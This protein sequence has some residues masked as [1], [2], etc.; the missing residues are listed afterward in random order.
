MGLSR[1]KR[2]KKI[3]GS[4]RLS[5]E[6]LKQAIQEAKD[7]AREVDAAQASPSVVTPSFPSPATTPATPAARARKPAAAPAKKDIEESPRD[8]VLVSAT[9]TADPILAPLSFLAGCLEMPIRGELAPYNQVFQ[10]L[11]NPS[12]GF[13]SNRDGMNLILLRFEDWLRNFV[14][15]DGHAAA[16]RTTRLT[17]TFKEY[18]NKTLADFI[19]ALQSYAGQTACH[20]H[21][22]LCP[23]TPAYDTRSWK[24]Q[25]AAMSRELLESVASL[26]GVDGIAAAEFH[27]RYQ[28]TAFHDEIRDQV[29]HIPFTNEYFNVLGALAMRRYFALSGIPSK[30]IV[31]DCD[32]TLWGG[33]CGEVGAEGIHL[34]EPFASL[35]KFL[36]RQAERGMVLCLC[37]KNA[38]EDV[39][40][41]FDRRKEMPLKREHVVDSR[42]NWTPKSQNLISLAASLNLGLDSFIFIDDNPVECA[43]V[44]ANCPE[45]LTFQWPDNARDAKRFLDH[46]WVFD[47]YSVTVEDRKRTKM[48]QANV[49]R[50]NLLATSSDFNKFL[51]NLEL[52]IGLS[53]V[54]AETLPRLAQLTNRTNQFNFTTM[55]RSENDVRKILDAQTHQ[56]WTAKVSDRFGD[57]GLVGVM[58]L[59]YGKDML[60][61]DSFLLSCRVLGR[62]VEYRMMAEVG[63][64]AQKRRLSRVEIPF[65]HTAKNEPARKFIEFI[66]Q[67]FLHVQNDQG[68]TFHFP[69]KKLAN[70]RFKPTK[71]AQAGAEVKGRSKSASEAASEEETLGAVRKREDFFL[72][73]RQD[74]SNMADL[75]RAMSRGEAMPDLPPSSI[76]REGPVAVT[77]SNAPAG[78]RPHTAALRARLTEELREIFGR[79]LSLSPSALDPGADLE[80]YVDDSFKNV[81]IMVGLT[82]AFEDIPTTILFEARSIAA[83]AELLLESDTEALSA[84][85]GIDRASRSSRP[86]QSATRSTPGLSTTAEAELTVAPTAG[87][88]EL[89]TTQARRQDI[90]IIGLSGKYPCANNLQELWR[91][92]V[93]GRYCV[94]EVPA[95]RW[96]M[97]A[98]F[99][100]NGKKPDKSYNKWGGFI[101]QVSRFDPSFFQITPKEAELMDPQQRL[102]LQV[103][104]ALLEDAGYVRTNLEKNTGVFVGVI[105]SDYSTLTSEAS[106]KGASAYRGSDYYQIPN[107]VSYFFDFK[108][109]SMAIDTACSASGTS[110]HMACESLRKGECKLAIAGG[111]NLFLHP[112]RYVQYAQLQFFSQDDKIRPFG[113]GATGTIFGEGIGA[114]LLKPLDDAVRDGDN[115]QGVIKAT[116]I[117]SGG[118]TNGFTVPNPLAQA[119]LIAGAL[120]RSNIDPRSISYIEAHGTGTPLGDPIEIRGLTLAFAR[121]SK[122]YRRKLASQF[123]AVGSIKSNIGHLE[124]GAAISGITKVL[125]QMR[126]KTLV[127]S[128]NAEKLNPKI[129]LEKTPFFIQRGLD[130]WQRPGFDED[131]R[132]ISF[133]RRAGISSFGAGGA[134]AHIIVE[135]FEREEAPLSS[136]AGTHLIV[137]SAKT[138]EA[139][140]R[141]AE[142]L[143]DF[144]ETPIPGAEGRSAPTNRISLEEIAYTQQTG[145]EAMGQRLAVITADM[146]ELIQKLHLFNAGGG[147]TNIEDVFKGNARSQKSQSDLLIS[148]EE[149]QEFLRL[150]IHNRRLAKLAQ[151]WVS[152]VS[153]DWTLIHSGSRPRRISLP[154]YPF[155]GL[156]FWIPE[157]ERQ[158]RSMEGEALPMLSGR[159]HP[160]LDSNEST[161]EEQFFKKRLNGKEF[162]LKDHVLNSEM[163][164]PAVAY[165]E[166]ARAAG[167]LASSKSRVWKLQ[168]IVWA[169]RI[170]L[171]DPPQDVFISLIP[172]S[173]AVEYEVFTRG[174]DEIRYMHAQGKLLYAD[175]SDSQVRNEVLDLRA[176][177]NRCSHKMTR[178]ACYEWYKAEG[179]DYGPGFK[180]IMELC[181]NEVE[182]LSR[183]EL[184]PEAQDRFEQFLLHPTIMDGALQS[185]IALTGDTVRSSSTPYL[186]FG[187]GE[188]EILQPLTDRCHAYVRLAANVKAASSHIKKFDVQIVDDN[189]AVLVRLKDYSL[190]AV[191]QHPKT[192]HLPNESTDCAVMYYRGAW[193]PSSREEPQTVINEPLPSRLLMFADDTAMRDAFLKVTPG[194]LARPR[195]LILVMPGSGFR[196]LGGST[197][198]IHPGHADD[199]HKLLKALAGK[200]GIP[201]HLLHFWSQGRFSS[202]ETLLNMQ[203]ER[204]FFSLFYLTQELM[205]QK[206]KEPLNLLYFFPTLAGEPKPQY[207]A[208]SGFAHT[209][210]QENPKFRLRTVAVVLPNQGRSQADPH[211][212]MKVAQTELR[213]GVVGDIELR[214]TQGR[215]FNKVLQEFD[216][217]QISQ[218][219]LAGAHSSEGG[220]TTIPLRQKGTYLITGGAGGLGLIFAEH[221]AKHFKANLALVGRSELSPQKEQKLAGLRSL[222]AD[223]HYFQADISRCERVRQLIGEVRSRFGTIHGIIH[224]AGVI[225]DSFVLKKTRAD[226]DQVLAAKVFGT[227]YLDQ[228]TRE[229]AL[230]FFVMFSSLT[231]IIGNLGQAD[232]AYGNRYMDDFAALR[233]TWRGKGKRSGK[234][235][236]INWPFWRDG[237]MRVDEH[238]R[239]MIT[240]TLGMKALSNDIG[241][242]TFRCGLARKE[243]QVLVV[244]GERSKVQRSLGLID[245]EP[246]R[247][248][249]SGTYTRFLSTDMEEAKTPEAVEP[250]SV[251]EPPTSI[252]SPPKRMATNVDED[253]LYQKAEHFLKQ[254]LSKESKLPIQKII[255][256]EPLEEYGIDSVMILTMNNELEKVF[257]DLS[258]TLLFEYQ[259]ISELAQYFVENHHEKLIESFGVSGKVIEEPLAESL[260]ERDT[261]GFVNPQRFISANM[262]PTP[263]EARQDEDIAII[264]LNGRFPRARDLEEFWHNLKTGKDCIEEIPPDRW[265]FRKFY[266][267]DK[268]KKGK[269][270]SKWGG[271]IADADQ[272]DPL[273]FNIS[274]REAELM[275]PQERVFLETACHTVEDAGYTR[276]SLEKFRVGVYVGVMWGQY[277][278]I[279]AEESLKGNVIATDSSYSTIANRV[280]YWFNLRGPSL[281]VDS[282]CSS[283]LTSIHL[284][285][286]SI[287]RGDIEMAIA[288]GVN[289]SLHPSKYIL[290][291]QGK[292][293]SSD[294]RCRSFGQGGDGYVPGEGSGAVMLKSLSKAISD[295]DHIYAII[296]GT[297]INHGGKTNGYSVPNPRAQ[298]DLVRGALERAKIDPLTLSY[299]EAHG[300]GTSLGDPIEITGLKRAFGDQAHKQLCPIGSVKSNIGHLEAAAGIAGLAKILLQLK[301]RQI[302]PSLHSKT[303]NPNINFKDS[304]FV[305]QQELA[306]WKQPV[307]NLNGEERT[308]PRRAGISSFGAGGSNAHV[309]VEE[310]QNQ[311]LATS[312]TA[313]GPQVIVLSAKNMDRL[314]AYTLDIVSFMEKSLE[315]SLL[316][317]PNEVDFVDTIKADLLGFVSKIL[318][319]ELN[320][321]DPN[322]DLKEYGFDPIS[323]TSLVQ[324]INDKYGL[325]INPDLF[326]LHPSLESISRI[327][328]RERQIIK[329]YF[330]NLKEK[331]HMARTI[332]SGAALPSLSDFA[333]TLQIG[334]EPLQERIALVVSNV[335]EMIDILKEFCQGREDMNEFYNGNIKSAKSKS[336][337]LIEGEEGKDFIKRIIGKRKLAKL[338][339]LWV[340]GVDIDWSLLH[341]PH[342]PKRISLPPQPFLRKRYWIPQTGQMVHSLPHANGV[343]Q[344]HPMVERNTSTFREERFSTRLDGDEFYLTDPGTLGIRAIPGLAFLELAFAAGGLAGEQKVRGIAKVAWATPVSLPADPGIPA[345]KELH[346]SLYPNGEAVEFEISTNG[347]G[348]NRILHS[349][350]LLRFETGIHREEREQLPLAEIQQRCSSSLDTQEAYRQLERGAFLYGPTLQVIQ[351]VYQGDS[352]A[353]ALLRLPEPLEESAHAFS[354]HPGLFAGV[355]QTI[356]LLLP[357]T[358][359][360]IDPYLPY[361]LDQLEVIGPLPKTCFAHVI[362]QSS[363]A[364][365]SGRRFKVLLAETSGRVLVKM[366]GLVLKP[367][368]QCRASLAESQTPAAE[369]A[370]YYRDIWERSDLS[371]ARSPWAAI[372]A[373]ANLLIFDSDEALFKTLQEQASGK[374]I[375]PARL[376]LVKPGKSYKQLGNGIFRIDPGQPEHYQKLLDT[377]KGEG[378]FPDHIIHIWSR[379]LYSGSTNKLTTLL[380][381]SIYSI[382]HL[383]R[384]LME[385]RPAQPVKLIYAFFGGKDDPQ[386][387]YAAMSAMI[388]TIRKESSRFLY[389]SVA[390]DTSS[391][392]KL[393]PPPLELAGMLLPEF[394][395]DRMDELEVR[396]GESQRWSKHL[397]SFDPDKFVNTWTAPKLS[398]DSVYLITGGA[399]GLGLIFARHIATQIKATLILTGR[400]DLSNEKENE[401]RALEALGSKVVYRKADISRREDVLGLLAEIR[402]KYGPL[403]GII[404][405][406]GIIRDASILKKTVEEIERVL[407]VKV[408]GTVYLDEVTRGDKLDFFV[409]FSSMTAI[410]GNAGQSDY[411]YANHFMD[412]FAEL[413][414]IL[415]AKQARC[416]KTIAINWPLWRDGGMRVDAQTEKLLEKTTGMRALSTEN[417][418]L[419]FSKGLSFATSRFLVVEGDN[420]KLSRI[421]EGQDSGKKARRAAQKT[422]APA[423]QPQSKS[424]AAEILT[425]LRTDLRDFISGLLKVEKK[426]I[427]LSADM[428]DFGF[429]SITLTEFSNHVN[430]RY[431]LEITPAIF[432]E[433]PSLESFS[434]FLLNEYRA[435]FSDHYQ[436][437]AQILPQPV[438]EIPAE[439]STDWS[440]FLTSE[441]RRR[442]RFEELHTTAPY[443][444]STSSGP[445]ETI[446]I[447][448]MAGVM[449]QSQDLESFWQHLE[450]GHD[451]ITEVPGDRWDWRAIYG[452]PALE[453]NKTNI[454]WG[455]FIDDV[456]KFDAGFFGIS[457]LEARFMDPQQRIFLETAWKTIEDSGYRPSDLSGT[458]TGMFVG[459]ASNDY[460]DLLKDQHMEIEAYLTTGTSHAIL[461]NR[462]SFLL[463]L[464][465]PSEPVD[466]ACSSSLVAIHRAVESLRNGDCEMAI[467]GAIN[468]LLSPT[469]F[470][471]GSKAGMLSED[472]RCKTFDKDANGYVRAEGAGAVMLKPLS[473]AKA[474]RDQIYAVIKGSALNHGGRAN[475]LTA[476]NPNA[477]AQLLIRAYEKANIDPTTIGYI[478][479]HGTGTPLGDPIE[480][481]GLKMAFKELLAKWGKPTPQKPYC[482]IGS[483]KSNVG[484]LEIAAGMAGLFKVILAMKYRKIPASIQIKTINPYIK[485]EDSPF[486]IIRETRDWEPLLDEQNKPLPLRAGISSFGFGGANAHIILEAWEEPRTSVSPTT[487]T[488]ALFV[489]SAKSN[490]RLKAYAGSLATYLAGRDEA[491]HDR[492]A[493]LAQV[494]RTLQMGR[495]EMEERLAVV[496]RN[497]TDLVRKLESYAQNGESSEEL[498]HGQVKA[499]REKAGL[500][501]EGKEGQ[502]FIMAIIADRKWSKLAQLWVMGVSIDWK[503]L[504]RDSG[505]HTRLPARISL[506]PYPFARTR[507]WIPQSQERLASGSAAGAGDMLHPLLSANTSTLRK[508]RFSSILHQHDF[509]MKDHVIGNDLVLPGVAYIEMARAAG[510]FAG[511]R[512]VAKIRDI[513]WAK[514][515]SLGDHT[516]PLPSQ[517][518]HIS[519][520]PTPDGVDYEVTTAGTEGIRALL[521]EGLLVFESAGRSPVTQERIDLG[522]IRSRCN[523]VL[524]HASCYR[525]FASLNLNYGPSFQSVREMHH[526]Q[527]EA[528][529]RLELPAHLQNGFDDF[530]LHPSLMDGALQAVSGLLTAPELDTQG[531]FLPYALREVEILAPLPRACYAHVQYAPGSGKRQA[532][533]TKIKKYDI[534][535][536]DESGRV[537]VKFKEFSLR[538]PRTTARAGA[539]AGDKAKPERPTASRPEPPATQAASPTAEAPSIGKTGHPLL[540]DFFIEEED[541]VLY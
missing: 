277:Q 209:V 275:D 152:G 289:L 195:E 163:V 297:T 436:R 505:G 243:T 250:P 385:S 287:H 466:T 62:G 283:S 207:A 463:N 453:T 234:S 330:E 225:R 314:K 175:H 446:A 428:S 540:D 411:G 268:N 244:V 73:N 226:I 477:Q 33:V 504:Y 362:L 420:Q 386:P 5:K 46:T 333:Y 204:G 246:R 499:A 256:E 522:Q 168:N 220:E 336:D 389:K 180:P 20:T 102:F 535:L 144:L 282:M 359:D 278:I 139:L 83:L 14:E 405:S 476:P 459:V 60:I 493:F 285:C 172:R 433:H 271:F 397:K 130:P 215:R 290:L 36:I 434:G 124:S 44:R 460:M 424:D 233:E 134:N 95:D 326:S 313:T 45:V 451:L 141:S 402:E 193:E 176:I 181:H 145:R 470:I 406:A 305:V 201:H 162:V 480:V 390:I 196:D 388:K 431:N 524:D 210:R 241:I 396:Y 247:E 263:S 259:S 255:A 337:L 154:T 536:V 465:G 514:P 197:Y 51:E 120:E 410:T 58:I 340:Y 501:I 438:S 169:R 415:T 237:G 468:L 526:G 516:H 132:H 178:E 492:P 248:A 400:S 528:L 34:G 135:E 90:A 125:M 212:L 55:R 267:P 418:L 148:G 372:P 214:Y 170:T 199:Y 96:N 133:P 286:E 395:D 352:E 151:L 444:D 351:A 510:S 462:I 317:E 261:S 485:L 24:K 482:G 230:D 252:A 119:D 342:P 521:S 422:Q 30:V 519:L 379:R 149:G 160:L 498:F 218:D 264:G 508:V 442:P 353:L 350:G 88:T 42:V 183:L 211:A 121:T 70:L 324:H 229:E 408:F 454:K 500:L 159:L 190:R 106:L 82:K 520:N 383:T 86:S 335:W 8:R 87:D 184:P 217:E 171:D 378:G 403:K 272:F 339:Q 489:L 173:D 22:L 138:E 473:K 17:R 349:R 394:Q 164:L 447:I 527:T 532:A 279:G 423:S 18:L 380:R 334:R 191:P 502:N 270:Y 2:K 112:S 187:M 231:S 461:A 174:E 341:L 306:E 398:A 75:A 310:Y 413:R 430:D 369:P 432:F 276:A 146:A 375:G 435:N 12:S 312:A 31:L 518:V 320:E 300:T 131:G 322:E 98:Y 316:V 179:F 128:L 49:G 311:P 140:L 356:D 26:S 292:F 9:F 354:L 361:T 21:L 239:K 54:T 64:I 253:E 77:D 254:V 318:N 240:E 265:D 296:K 155:E 491:E 266:H 421:L 309:I 315:T 448:G 370:L 79:A 307:V 258:K 6:K 127:P 50:E 366:D 65:L 7:L 35:Q 374:T 11:L 486:T 19:L 474:D 236:A 29:G 531:P 443:R 365:D 136:Q 419:A 488:P 47:R 53:P 228:E 457:K 161:L 304:P 97:A 373:S 67:P 219:V 143:A 117:N 166:M 206:L 251:L 507:F 273:F 16:S 249:L 142:N 437:G 363:A 291:S 469:M 115:I 346:I 479:T 157:R 153:I 332:G 123:C 93:E 364:R 358:K 417:G 494:A 118:K 84:R 43:E 208:V 511:E 450:R 165:L 257:G 452:D 483:V 284:A 269:T 327:L 68:M 185:V 52:D 114:I 232:Y 401:L 238:A 56:C 515:I 28:V 368:L 303:L 89:I 167:N 538:T 414:E 80:T 345:A 104:W 503:L 509:F 288:G 202:D 76:E 534:C 449:P 105:A 205:K 200:G 321:V 94:G 4:A 441:P 293:T 203:L 445:D 103:V 245:R 59:E 382:F 376:W 429:D 213:Q 490:D 137:L 331:Q 81:E 464:H 455:G 404:H 393:T 25:F 299:L 71:P 23:A 301:Y 329:Y 407:A 425:P 298:A 481:N 198:E 344:L 496:A 467:A 1:I 32:N 391:Q 113:E 308:Y 274:P 381:E 295:G 325:H 10:E 177:R 478:E 458:R 38:E 484:H 513:V 57:Y 48:Y 416:G 100:P 37:S 523:Q 371:V 506:P 156:R 72:H 471:A 347:E 302:V 517:E 280:S 158:S 409:L 387:Q 377:L 92:L 440:H 216:L 456:D 439:P 63:K 338:A 242:N 110:I 384:G 221:L 541:S 61:L 222:G 147:Q 348:R 525:L 360:Q 74:W 412:N 537:L 497:I 294:G 15:K 150:I 27:E 101:D 343:A 323:L 41:V 182:A 426:D 91:N 126:H 487:E 529:A 85:Y 533:T 399:G 472:G 189:G 357:S 188:V 530:L 367:F 109:P 108:G 3:G 66:A 235:L 186:P 281:A 192:V 260:E 122:A 39:W 427:D 78:P 40:A 107:R 111:V 355:L 262:P 495:E 539:L 319:V 224:A 99:D 223:I 392:G 116:A 328:C 512:S 475:S 129:E 227:I 194:N 13:R 69:S